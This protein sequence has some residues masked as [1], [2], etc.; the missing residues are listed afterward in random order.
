[1]LLSMPQLFQRKQ[2]RSFAV[3]VTENVANFW[4]TYIY[5]ETAT[6]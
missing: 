3:R 5:N 1:M 4:Q 6:V 2:E